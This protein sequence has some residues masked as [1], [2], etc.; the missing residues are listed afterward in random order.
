MHSYSAPQTKKKRKKFSAN[1]VKSLLEYDFTSK[2]LYFANALQISPSFSRLDRGM[3]VNI[4]F[5]LLPQVLD[6]I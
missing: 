6:W 5:Q 2:N 1:T 3:S 4:N